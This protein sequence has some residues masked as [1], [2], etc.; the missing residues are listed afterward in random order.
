V[1]TVADEAR[2]FLAQQHQLVVDSILRLFPG[3]LDGH[4]FRD[5]PQAEPEPILPIVDIV[6]GVAEL[7]LHQLDKQPDWSFDET[8]SGKA[9]VERLAK[10]GDPD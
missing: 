5:A 3:V 1:A 9:P 7:D 10:G 2:C 4:L 6:D 8:D